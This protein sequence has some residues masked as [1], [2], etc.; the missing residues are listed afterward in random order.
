MEELLNKFIAES[1]KIHDEHSSLI[2]EI[3]ASTGD[4]IKNQGAS[5]KALE[6][7]IG[8]I[9]KVCQEGGSRSLPSSTK[10]NPRDHVKSI[11]TSEEAETLKGND[12]IPLIKLIQTTIPFPAWFSIVTNF[13]IVKDTDAYRDKHMGDVIVGKPFCRVACVKAK[14]FQYGVSNLMDTAY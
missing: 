14:R 6:I 9:S 13:A 10:I 3:R 11:T 12:K 8:Q 2:K 7:R 5:I 1:E 4:A